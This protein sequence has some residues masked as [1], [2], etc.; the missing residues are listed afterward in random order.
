MRFMSQ[1]GWGLDGLNH[2]IGCFS[3]TGSQEE[4]GMTVK[5]GEILAVF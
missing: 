1:P 5:S 4:D 3:P 2:G